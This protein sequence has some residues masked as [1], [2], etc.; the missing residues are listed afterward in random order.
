MQVIQAATTYKTLLPFISS[1]LLPRLITKKVWTT[2][3][4]WEGFIRCVKVCV[5]GSYAAVCLLPKENLGDL[6]GR[7]GMESVRE[8]VR[9]FLISST[10]SL[11]L[12]GGVLMRSCRTRERTSF[13]ITRY[14]GPNSS[15]RIHSHS[16][17]LVI[18]AGISWLHQSSQ[19]VQG[20]ISNVLI[21][22]SAPELTS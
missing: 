14:L 5:P 3:P 12:L 18:R 9:D 8:G 7:A 1:T 6:V 10:S 17:T 16:H 19:V 13:S 11:S 22:P 15:T 2:P 21:E 4:L 20:E